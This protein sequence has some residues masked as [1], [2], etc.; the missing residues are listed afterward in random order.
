MMRHLLKLVWNRKRANALIML[1]IFFTF[2]VVFGVGTLGMYLWDNWRHPL[3]FDWKN[4]WVVQVDMQQQTDDTFTPEQ[5]ET[6]ARLAR[7]VGSLEPVEGVAGAMLSPYS[8]GGY[9]SGMNMNGHYLEM[10]FDQVSEGFAGVMRLELVKGRWFE[11]ADAVLSWRPIVIDED[12]AHEVWGDAGP[13]GKRL[14]DPNPKEPEPEMRVI[15]VVRDFREHGELSGPG[16][17]RFDYKQLGNPKYRPPRALLARVRPGTPA[18]FEEELTRRMQGVARDWSFKITPLEQLRQTA[19]RRTITPLI[20]GGIVAF[21][22]LLMVALGLL[23]VL[24]QNLLQRTR[25]IGLRRAIGA[26]RQEVHR[27]II[28]EQLLL[29]TLGVLLGTI[30]VVQLP[31][32]DVFG[33]ALRPSVFVSG[34]VVAMVSMYVLAAVCALYPSA[35]ASRVQPAEALRYE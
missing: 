13:L 31:V 11:P 19:F 21:F 35:M 25:E 23:G 30:V 1:E 4:V 33:S 12:L 14:G 17:F 32:L 28:M 24:W 27:Q 9:R 26:S 15:G 22:L 8:F 3:G 34:L 16:N 29:T 20:V 2:L 18:A 5:V 6:T 10:D 7:E